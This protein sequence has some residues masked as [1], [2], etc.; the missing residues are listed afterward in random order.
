MVC[1]HGKGFVV[2]VLSHSKPLH[3][4][5]DNCDEITTC[6]ETFTLLT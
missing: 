3:G 4:V 6:F 5:K 2:S 1:A